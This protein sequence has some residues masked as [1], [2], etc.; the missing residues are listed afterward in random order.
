[1]NNFNEKALRGENRII[2]TI[3]GCEFPV[4]IS[5]ELNPLFFPYVGNNQHKAG[6]CHQ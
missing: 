4:F 5:K 3:A 1:M 6:R 2:A